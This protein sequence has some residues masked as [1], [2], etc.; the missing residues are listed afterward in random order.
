MPRSMLGQG[1]RMTSF[2]PVLR[3]TGLP[4]SSTTSGTTPK[5]GSVA[6][7]GFV[8]IAPGNGVIMM[9]PVSVCHH[10]STIGHRLPPM[11]SRYQIHASGL[12]GSPTVPSNRSELKS[13][14]LG[15]SVPHFMKAQ[16]RK[17]TRLNSSHSQISYAVFCLK[18]KNKNI[19]S[20]QLPMHT[21]LQP[22]ANPE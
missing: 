13:C 21:T 4:S 6:E 15:H 20:S 1:F 11:V 5:N 12:I 3:G 10:V 22:K 16:D 19:Q 8:A 17:S 7:P 14:F 9:P 18:K 2:P